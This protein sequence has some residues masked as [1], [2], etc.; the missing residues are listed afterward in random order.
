MDLV[1]QVLRTSKQQK[2]LKKRQRNPFALAALISAHRHHM[3]DY[4]RHLKRA[5]ECAKALAKMGYQVKDPSDS[6]SSDD[7]QV[8]GD[9]S[10]KFTKLPPQG[11]MNEA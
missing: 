9:F 4:R 11:D 1:D 5:K 7:G 8:A 2:V 3:K 10:I 6:E